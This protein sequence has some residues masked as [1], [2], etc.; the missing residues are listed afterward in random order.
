MDKTNKLLFFS[1]LYG[2][3]F[4]S[5]KGRKP[6]KKEIKIMKIL[7]CQ[8]LGIA[9]ECDFVATGEDAD[10]VVKKMDKYLKD[11]FSSEYEK[12]CKNDDKCD[13]KMRDNVM[14][15]PES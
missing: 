6:P 3:K 9:K 14:D 13:K 8:D 10:T 4:G 15:E 11:N 12:T 5:S 7:N 2:K 1:F